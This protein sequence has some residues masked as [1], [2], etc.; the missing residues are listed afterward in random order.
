MAVHQLIPTFAE[1]DATGLAAIHL[2]LLLRR[3]GLFG[4]IYAAQLSPGLTSLVRPLAAFRPA[5][6][7][8]ALYHH[9]IASPLA[10]RLLH[11]PCRK[12]IVFHNISPV[13]TYAGTLLE[14]Q[15]QGGRAQL[16]AMAPFVE[17]AIG[18]SDFN[19]RELTGAGFRNVF[20][21]P[22][23]VEPERFAED[24]ADPA[25]DRRLA[26]EGLTLLSVSR[27][28]P[29]KRFEDL[30]ALHA[31]VLRLDPSARL[32]LVGGYEAGGA[33]F[34]GL[35]RRARSLSGV[36]FLG[37]LSHAEL[38]A[39]YRTASVFVSMSEHEGFGVPL[40]EAMAAQLPVLAYGAAA[41][42]ETL[43]GAGV[44]FDQ[45]HFALL[46]E[47]ACELGREGK[48]RQSVLRGQQRRLAELS[49]Q[50]AGEK[51]ALALRSV[52]LTAA[53][54]P[55]RRRRRAR[56]KV[57][58]V[59]DR[60]GEVTGGAELLAR[61]LSERLSSHWDLTVLTSCARDHLT[62]ANAFPEGETQEG[63][64]RVLRFPV[65]RQRRMRDFNA[66]CRK[67]Y[68]RPQER[69]REEH[70][71]AEQ[72]PLVPGLLRHL[73]DQ[74]AGY[75]GFVCFTYLYAPVVWGLPMVADR[76]IMVPTTHDE[77]PIAFG[78]YRDVFERP[79]R[80]FC[81]TPEEL[82]LVDRLFPRHAPAQVVSVGVEPQ[83]ASPDRFRERY[84]VQRPYLLYVGRVEKGK[85]LPELLGLHQQMVRR[86]HDAPELLIA[87]AAS[88]TVG[89]EKVRYLGRIS[90]QDKADGLTGAVAAVVPSRYESLSLL[91][92]EAFAQGTPA[93]VNGESQVLAGQIARSGAGRTYRDLA[94]FTAG[95]REIGLERRKLSAR[96]VA[97]AR[98]HSWSRVVDAYLAAMERIM[99]GGR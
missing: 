98:K 40:L 20:T 12:G 72:G 65:T 63:K 67:L 59:V 32:H 88:M 89:G 47:L 41:V 96:A 31:E 54:A 28:L 42:P 44:S 34:R 64:T 38:V 16:A 50:T 79:R 56:P 85:G 9:G 26:G 3:Q 13:R 37:R 94:S 30:L 75:D 27:V 17:L 10:G 43:G 95:V 86:F 99:E 2:Q 58:F 61:Q 84:G 91:T 90:E 52:G 74:G 92:L 19:S 83:P 48:L 15:L 22:L 11:L 77:P 36:E 66:Y 5:P 24:R 18:D 25:L 35:R 55:A 21:V 14:E 49:A 76:A 73:A 70:F 71:V 78:V 33:Y 8:L 82:A 39:A 6:E 7:D 80:L 1:G 62:W 81:L 29:H 45:K 93:L 69:V 68:G 51:L 60:F 87:G 4:E 97:Y 53:P 23:F 46:A 57:A